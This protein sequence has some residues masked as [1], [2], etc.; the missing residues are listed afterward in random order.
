MRRILL[1]AV[2]TIIG[3]SLSACG[4]EAPPRPSQDAVP[5]PKDEPAADTELKDRV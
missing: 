2:A 3:A 5:I 1:L 4:D